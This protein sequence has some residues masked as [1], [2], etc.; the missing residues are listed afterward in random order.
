MHNPL[1]DELANI[2]TTHSAKI[3]PYKFV[4]IEG[5]NIQQEMVIAL[6]PVLTLLIDC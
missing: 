4:F 2:L 5:I 1:F 6:F 3:Q